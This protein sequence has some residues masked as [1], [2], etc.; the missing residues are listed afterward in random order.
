MARSRAS[1]T[2]CANGSP[3][4]ASDGSAGMRCGWRD[5]RSGIW[6][7]CT[8]SESANSNRTPCP[9][10]SYVSKPAGRGEETTS[11]RLGGAN[12]LGA[13]PLPAGTWGVAY[14][15]TTGGAGVS[16]CVSD[17][18]VEGNS[19]GSGGRACLRR[20]G[21]S[22]ASRTGGAQ[23]AEEP[24]VWFRDASPDSSAGIDP[25]RI[26]CWGTS[27]GIGTDSSASDTEREAG[28]LTGKYSCIAGQR[29]VSRDRK[30]FATRYGPGPLSA[31]T[32]THQVCSGFATKRAG[33][34]LSTHTHPPTSH[35]AHTFCNIDARW[36]VCIAIRMQT[37][38]S[39]QQD[40][41]KS[42]VLQCKIGAH[43]WYRGLLSAC[44][45]C[46]IVANCGASTA[47]STDLGNTL[48]SPHLTS[49][50]THIHSHQVCIQ[51]TLELAGCHILCIRLPPSSP[52]AHIHSPPSANCDA[53]QVQTQRVLAT[54]CTWFALLHLDLAAKRR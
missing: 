34:A 17:C 40:R 21:K 42:V 44:T 37:C 12:A 45:P 20:A 53:S 10:A 32:L 27:P 11:S 16:L 23:P 3:A 35:S 14:E 4:L 29:G 47:N 1:A 38:G 18:S 33:F 24:F 9:L 13:N 5:G 19:N 8:W 43:L 26:G 49:H 30:V 39:W 36:W 15:H 6:G 25:S 48:H 51:H 31:H 50:S 7:G 54:L 28:I 2:R 22:I 41:C 52:L 46:K